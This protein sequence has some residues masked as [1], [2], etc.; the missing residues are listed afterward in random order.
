MKLNS[1][2]LAVNLDIIS[3]LRD[4]ARVREEASKRRAAGSIIPKSNR[5]AS[6]P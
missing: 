1:E 2:S 5:E 3:E 6:V 4:R